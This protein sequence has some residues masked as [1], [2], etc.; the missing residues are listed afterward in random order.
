MCN[1]RVRTRSCGASGVIF[2][3]Y[4]KPHALFLDC[5]KPC[6][7]K[8]QTVIYNTVHGISIEIRSLDPLNAARKVIDTYDR[9]R[10]MYLHTRRVL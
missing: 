1:L 3:S 10:S 7:A 8:R 4:K 2:A 9:E 5:L 6:D